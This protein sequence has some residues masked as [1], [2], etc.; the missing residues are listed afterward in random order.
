L[1]I[2]IGTIAGSLFLAIFLWK[3]SADLVSTSNQ[4]SKVSDIMHSRGSSSTK[5]KKDKGGILKNIPMED[6]TAEC[7]VS[8]R[9]PKKVLRWCGL[10]TR[11]AKQ[12]NLSPDLVA[13]VILQESGGNPEAYSSSGAVGLMQVMPRDGL[14]AAFLCVNGPCFKDRP[15]KSKLLNPEFNLKYGTGILAR[16]HKNHGDLREAL[17]FYGPMDV[18]YGY[19]DKVLATYDTNHQ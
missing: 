2:I 12:R 18:G 13:A 7:A 4:D 8:Q 6:A 17:R 11:Y 1:L 19:A 16:L 5:G 14:A 15:S 3:I 9:Y 10:I